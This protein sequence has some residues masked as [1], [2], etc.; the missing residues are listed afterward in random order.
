MLN[1]GHASIETP[2]LPFKIRV[3]TRP[4]AG[5]LKYTRDYST[6]NS[7][8][9]V[10]AKAAIPDGNALALVETRNSNFKV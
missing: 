7:V 10:R 3:F 9:V 1:T 2:R 8:H 6:P 4:Y 5:K